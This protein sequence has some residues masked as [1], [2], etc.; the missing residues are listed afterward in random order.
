[1]CCEGVLRKVTSGL[2][3][4]YLLFRQEAGEC[5]N[6]GVDILLVRLAVAV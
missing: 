1:V 2:L 3:V 5:D 6:V 4:L